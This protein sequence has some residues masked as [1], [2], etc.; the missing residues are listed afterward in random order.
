MEVL[1]T[2]QLKEMAQ[3]DRDFELI[4]VLPEAAFLKEHIPDSRNIPVDQEEF[5]KRVEQVVGDKNKTVVVY[6]ASKECDASPKAAKKL[7]AAGFSSVH[8]YE[9]GMK[10]WKEAGLPV[11]SA[12]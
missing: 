11:R 1:N 6:C 5:E 9:A 10:G 4:N 2:A 7:E 12:A 8:D 3:R